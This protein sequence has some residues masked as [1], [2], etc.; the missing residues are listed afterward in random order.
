MVLTEFL[1]RAKSKHGDTFD[2][3]H[4]PENFNKERIEI[5]CPIHGYFFTT[6]YK[7]LN[8]M[9]GCPECG[10]ILRVKNSI[11]ITRE[12][13]IRR[14]IEIHGDKYDYS[15]VEFIS[16]N[17]NVTII[18]PKHGRFDQL[19]TSHINSGYGCDKCRKEYGGKHAALSTDEF[20]KRS[21]EKH[22]DKYDYSKAHYINRK[23]KITIICPIHGEFSQWP[24][25]HMWGIGCRK[26]GAS[27]TGNKLRK[28][29]NTFIEEC[30]K[31]HG[32]FYD[33][34]K[35]NY[36]KNNH[37]VTIICPKHGAFNQVAV[38]HLRGSNCPKCISSKGEDKIMLWLKNNNIEYTSQKR[39]SGCIY[40][41]SLCF[42]FYIP[43]LNIIIEF[44]GK[45]HY[46]A[47]EHFGGE[48]F[49][50]IQTLKDQ[51]KSKFCDDN[52]LKMIIIKYDE[53]DNIEKILDDL[54]F[55]HG[56]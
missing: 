34:S 27:I 44:D 51:I 29:Q 33:Y 28:D 40:K 20:I 32:N 49:L 38:M 7:H 52:G 2:Y 53:F 31:V 11:R 47:V 6:Q 37:E 41:K 55:S 19:A 4:I 42:D 45:Q 14:A 36:H 22:G 30:K 25:S 56:Y 54:F 17:N 8:T 10:R 16:I 46:E 3:S 9:S 35:V 43:K 21:K 5:G 48:D 18:C 15:E 39:F 1:K 23:N 13:F 50:K 24:H 26:C 12:E